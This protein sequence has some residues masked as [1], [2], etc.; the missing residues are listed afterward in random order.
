MKSLPQALV[1]HLCGY[2]DLRSYH[3]LA[4]CSKIIYDDCNSPVA[5]QHQPPL[6]IDRFAGVVPVVGNPLLL[7]HQNLIF[8]GY[9]E[10]LDKIPKM[11]RERLKLLDS[12]K[13]SASM[14][15]ELLRD[16]RLTSLWF[17]DFEDDDRGDSVDVAAAIADNVSLTTFKLSHSHMAPWNISILL[18][19]GLVHNK[20]ITELD[21]SGCKFLPRAMD[22][23]CEVIRHN[24]TITALDIEDS[25]LDTSANVL[26]K[27]LRENKTLQELS[28]GYNK[29]GSAACVEIITALQGNPSLRVLD[30]G[31]VG[32]G[33]EG[34]VALAC[35][36]DETNPLSKCRLTSLRM[37]GNGIGELGARA[38]AQSLV[39]NKTLQTLE[40][41]FIWGDEGESVIGDLG[42]QH[43]ALALQANTGLTD[44]DLAGCAAG[45]K[46]AE[47]LAVAIGKN[48]TLKSL[49]LAENRDFGAGLRALVSLGGEEGCA[50]EMFSL[51]N[52]NVDL[53]NLRLLV[54]AI[55]SAPSLTELDL[56]GND[57]S[58]SGTEIILG[59]IVFQSHLKN[60]NLSYCSLEVV[61]NIAISL[62]NSSLTELN[63]DN[64]AFSDNGAKEL[65]AALKTNTALETLSLTECDIG[66]YGC[67]AG[68]SAL[69]DALAVNRTLRSLDLYGN[70]LG[71]VGAKL[72]ASA[73]PYNRSLR[74]L[75]VSQSGCGD[76][77]AIAFADALLHGSSVIELQIVSC[78]ITNTGAIALAEGAAFNT[79]LRQL[80]LSCNMIGKRG[81]DVINKA[82]LQNLS[83]GKI[84]VI[85]NF[86]D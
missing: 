76:D 54:N 12:G 60:L 61:S 5:L 40:L 39:G 70:P 34:A 46:S 83:L 1:R 53:E 69:A 4:L 75:V 52:C 80:H 55:R 42:V 43:V 26:A 37:Y 2:L 17:R 8:D 19:N 57:F 58:S 36:L 66:K 21:I 79:R 67:S 45:V 56:H 32:M 38:I 71:E 11:L 33:V 29:F 47:P 64:N 28:I 18:S 3:N 20:S 25:G 50:L 81:C 78:G 77:G 68:A 84:N 72:L 14:L 15:V 30:I 7:Q 44:V 49:C 23:L 73:L 13:V 74:Q 63:L 41:G 10:D 65:A 9:S 22:G 86:E 31:D 16:G 27:A 82:L 51:A 24:T 62:R 6:N 59:C 85:H 48:K 35:L